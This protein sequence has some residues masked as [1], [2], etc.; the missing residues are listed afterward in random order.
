MALNSASRA[1]FRSDSYMR[2]FS[3]PSGSLGLS[4]KSL[5][6][7]KTHHLSPHDSHHGLAPQG[8]AVKG[9]VAASEGPPK[10]EYP[11]LPQWGRGLGGGGILL[12]IRQN[13]QNRLQNR[14]GLLQ[15]V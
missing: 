1:I 12:P 6:L 5:L 14:L 8:P 10:S 2:P 13:R 7:R 9:A 3:F 15:Y 4:R 11:P